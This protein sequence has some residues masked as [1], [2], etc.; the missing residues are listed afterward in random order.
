MPYQTGP[1][2]WAPQSMRRPLACLFFCAAFLVPAISGGQVLTAQDELRAMGN[3]VAQLQPASQGCPA[4][5]PGDHKGCRLR[6]IW[7]SAEAERIKGLTSALLETDTA[8]YLIG[9][10]FIDRI[11]RCIFSA[12]P[13]SAGMDEAAAR[14]AR[15][16]SE[17]VYKL[18][19]QSPAFAT[20]REE[21]RDRLV[22]D[23]PIAALDQALEVNNR[24][25]GK[26]LIVAYLANALRLERT[27]CR[28]LSA[29]ERQVIPQI[30]SQIPR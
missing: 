6:D 26:R 24:K 25:G 21:L 27:D 12:T 3:Q 2:A 1:L 22:L 9:V 4:V 8:H 13:Q 10:F 14:F 16:G 5:L 15:F 19:A 17:D 7:A 29:N 23:G 28:V 18:A 30:I 20:Y 11:S